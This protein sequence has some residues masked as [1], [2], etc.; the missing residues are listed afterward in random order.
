MNRKRLETSY[1]AT[2]TMKLVQFHFP[3]ASESDGRF[4][5]ICAPKLQRDH[6]YYKLT[7]PELG[8]DLTEE[9]RERRFVPIRVQC[10]SL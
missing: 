6:W 1:Y 2:E 10:G 9:R 5:P 8:L 3:F 4:I 7:L